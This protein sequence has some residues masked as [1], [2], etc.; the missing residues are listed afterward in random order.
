[1]DA[2]LITVNVVGLFPSIPHDAGSTALYEKLEERSDK[3]VPSVD[4]V[5]MAEFVIKKNFFEFDTKV[6]QHIS[7]IGTKFAPSCIFMYFHE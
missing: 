6:K 3:K 1:M 4:L 2:F 5:H 7:G